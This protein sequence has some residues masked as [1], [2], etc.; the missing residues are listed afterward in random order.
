MTNLTREQIASTLGP[1]TT[2][3]RIDPL[4]LSLMRYNARQAI[5]NQ[6]TLWRH[7]GQGM[8][9]AYLYEGETNEARIHIW[10]P[11]LQKPDILTNG[12]FHDHRFAMRSHVI[13]GSIRH[14]DCSVHACPDDPVY[15]KLVEVTHARKAKVDGDDYHMDPRE[16]L[17]RYGMIM[18]D[19]YIRDAT[20]IF[21]KFRY[22]RA[23][24]NDPITVTIVI[25]SEQEDVNARLIN[26]FQQG[27]LINSF[28][29][30]MTMRWQFQHVL[31]ATVEALA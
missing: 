20:Y 6:A 17:G 1:V 7:N 26:Q 10:H 23:V 3:E 8:L 25:K 5:L 31:D 14:T 9:Q 27:P 24:S 18:A 4:D 12:L 11:D 16:L 28:E 2:I 21:P 29:D 22:H 30:V 19:Y 13:L 15:V